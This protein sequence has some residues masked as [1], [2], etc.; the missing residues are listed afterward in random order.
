MDPALRDASHETGL[1]IRH[2]V[3]VQ[4]RPGASGT[5]V[6][7][8][9]AVG[10]GRVVPVGALGHDA[11][12]L[13]LRAEFS[14]M[15]LG[16]DFLLDRPGRCTLSYIRVVTLPDLRETER[17]DVF[18][19]SPLP[20]EVEDALLRALGGSRLHLRRRRRVGLHRARQAG[21]GDAVGVRGHLGPR[22]PRPGTRP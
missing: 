6:N 11:D 5:V 7:Q 12:A 4:A 20:R 15:G 2:V 13:F 16:T 17:L 22:P 19:R 1:P 8:A 10:V 3:D 18:P 21:R 9:H 14:R